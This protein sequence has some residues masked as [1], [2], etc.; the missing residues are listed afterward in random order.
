VDVEAV[1][2]TQLAI[3]LQVVRLRFLFAVGVC[4]LAERA[5]REQAV[6][7]DV[8]PRGPEVLRMIK[9]S[10]T[11]SV[12]VDRPDIVDPLRSLA[13]ALFGAFKTFCIDDVAFTLWRFAHRVHH[14]KA[15]QAFL[16][17]AEFDVLFAIA[18][19]PNV[20]RQQPVFMNADDGRLGH[21]RFAFG[22][23]PLIRDLHLRRIPLG[24]EDPD[25]AIRDLAFLGPVLD[26]ADL[27]NGNP[28]P[29]VM[30]MVAA[31]AIEED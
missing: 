20:V 7:P 18:G 19:K 15:E 25:L 14:P 9:Q 1:P 6:I 31:L 21:N 23:E 17:V 5:D 26:A 12:S 24:L 30:R 4:L 3:R 22:V 28:D 16:R 29:F 13:P 8:V 2:Q 10:D 11:I 27:V